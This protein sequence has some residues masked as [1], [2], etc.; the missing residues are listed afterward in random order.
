DRLRDLLAWVCLDLGAISYDQHRDVKKT[1]EYYQECL[2]IREAIMNRLSDS[3]RQRHNATLKPEDR[4]Q[5]Y[6]NRLKVSEAY[7][8]IALIHFFEGDSAQAEAP[9]LKSV[10]MRETLVR[11]TLAGEAAF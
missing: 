10:P 1:L 6:F 5:P 9:L 2:T 11:E 4:L 8:R 3:E 7:T